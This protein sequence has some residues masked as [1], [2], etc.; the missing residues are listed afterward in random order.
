MNIKGMASQLDHPLP[1][2]DASRSSLPRRRIRGRSVEKSDGVLAVVPGV[3]A[4]LIECTRRARQA[5][6]YRLWIDAR[7]C[8][9]GSLPTLPTLHGG[10]RVKCLDDTPQGY[11]LDG[12]IRGF[13]NDYI[14]YIP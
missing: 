7:Y 5:L 10:Y 11:I 8:R 12:A 3:L 4:E 1:V 14:S 13:D 6:R 9:L 2:E